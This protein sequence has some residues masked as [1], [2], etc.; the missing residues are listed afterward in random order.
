MRFVPIVSAALLLAS[1]VAWA[2]P[3]NQQVYTNFNNMSSTD[4]T[5]G[6]SPNSAHFTGGEAAFRGIFELYHFGISNDV[7]SWF[8][9]AGDTGTIQFETNAA[10]VEFYGRRR[11]GSTVDG[12]LTAFDDNG[13]V[14]TSASLLGGD[15]QFFSWTGSIDHI[16]FTNND[17]TQTA[18]LDDFGFTVVPEP[19]FAA[20]LL[21]GAGLLS[22][23]R[24]R[25]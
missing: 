19:S 10:I 9:D 5:I 22:T 11:T 2:A 17:P 12:T 6:T 20:A 8:V 21:V 13:D 4:F 25:R 18:A 14:I 7:Y 23:V 3:Q 1:T 15:W 16:T 24:R